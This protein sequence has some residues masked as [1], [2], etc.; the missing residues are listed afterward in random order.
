[1]KFLYKTKSY[2]CDHLKTKNDKTLQSGIEVLF[3]CANLN[4]IQLT[5]ILSTNY[6]WHE[7]SMFKPILNISK[8]S[9]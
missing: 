9:M 1:M 8:I 3:L 7:T 4:Y 5:I 2:Y 6:Q